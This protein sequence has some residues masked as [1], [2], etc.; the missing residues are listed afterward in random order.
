MQ[1]CDTRTQMH[2]QARSMFNFPIIMK[3]EDIVQMRKWALDAHP[4][5]KIFNDFFKLLVKGDL[6]CQFCIMNGFTWQVK[7]NHYSFHLHIPQMNYGQ[8][9]QQALTDPSVNEEMLK[10]FPQTTGHGSY[11]KMDS[12]FKQTMRR[13]YCYSSYG[14]REAQTEIWR[15]LCGNVDIKNSPNPEA[16]RFEHIKWP[17][18]QAAEIMQAHQ[19]RLSENCERSWDRNVLEELRHEKLEPLHEPDIY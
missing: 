9:R 8:I 3:L 11:E 7:H 6:F 1:T 18:Q 17:E 10:A 5:L 13:G 2:A 16:W 15:E 19:H 14:T 12:K 4:E